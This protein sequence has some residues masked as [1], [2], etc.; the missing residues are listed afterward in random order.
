[1][2]THIDALVGYINE[3]H[4][5]ITGIE[6]KSHTQRFMHKELTSVHKAYLMSGDP[7][8]PV[9]IDIYEVIIFIIIVIK[10]D[11]YLIS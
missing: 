8:T 7:S 3:L 4:K 2:D 10:Y 11:R 1:M 5:R 9:K 6:A